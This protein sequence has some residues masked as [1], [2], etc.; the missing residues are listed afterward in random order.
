M[1]PYYLLPNRLPHL[2]LGRKDA[3]TTTIDNSLGLPGSHE[4]SDSVI[5]KFAA[6]GF[7]KAE[8]AVLIGECA[9]TQVNR[10]EWVY[11]CRSGYP[12]QQ[13]IGGLLA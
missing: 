5:A 6:Q 3:M 11:M 7:S 13:H 4:D 1:Q 8:V 12:G 2:L 10:N 9:A